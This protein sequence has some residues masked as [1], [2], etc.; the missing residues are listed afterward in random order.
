MPFKSKAQMKKFADMV[1]SGEMK[2]SVFDEWMKD[3]DVKSLPEK[4]PAAKPGIIR[5]PRRLAK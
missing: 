4:S 5:R 1:E 3:T 2:Q